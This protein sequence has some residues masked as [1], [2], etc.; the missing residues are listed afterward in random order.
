MS[1]A[2]TSLFRDTGPRNNLLDALRE[3]DFALLQPSLSTR[4]A[5]RGDVL[6]EP[7]D[8]VRYVYFPCG[9]TLVSFLVLQDEGHAVETAL[10]GREGAI[11]GV[12]SQGRLPAF[13]RVQVQYGGTLL[14]MEAAALE[15]AKSRSK[16]LQNLFARYADCVMAQ[17]FQAVACNATHTIEQRAAKWLLAAIV[18][19]GDHEVPLTQD[20]L[21][22]MLGVGRGY[23]SRVIRTFKEKDVLATRRGGLIVKDLDELDRVSCRCNDAVHRHFDDV[24]KGVYPEPTDDGA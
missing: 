11:G 2:A 8:A 24:L 1:V 12:V 15:D 4:P 17:V 14:R 13:A 23:V 21:A 16:T 10:V 19:T 20:Q 22:R 5:D 9:R 3:D 7:G 6:Y 18:R